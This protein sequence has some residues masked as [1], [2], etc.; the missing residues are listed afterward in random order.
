MLLAGQTVA[1]GSALEIRAAQVHIAKD[2]LP[3]TKV[4]GTISGNRSMRL[5]R[6]TAMGLSHTEEIPALQV[7]NLDRVAITAAIRDPVLAS[8]ATTARLGLAVL[9]RNTARHITAR[10]LTRAAAADQ[11]TSANRILAAAEGAHITAMAA[12]VE[13]DIRPAA[14]DPAVAVVTADN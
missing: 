10:H 6:A 8:H 11:S 4:D 3:A 9:H 5:S 2:L 1:A 14:D 12:V 13:A 7:I